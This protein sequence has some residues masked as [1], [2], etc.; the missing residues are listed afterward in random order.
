MRWS[1]SVKARI[2]AA[3]PPALRVVKVA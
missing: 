1:R 3:M 2:F